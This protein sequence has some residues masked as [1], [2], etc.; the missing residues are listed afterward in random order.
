MV[1]TTFPPAFPEPLRPPSLD[2]LPGL[3][4]STAPR[5]GPPAGA[6]L[7]AGAD[8]PAGCRSFF[9]AAGRAEGC[10][11]DRL[12][13]AGRTERSRRGTA[14][15]EQG[16]TAG[17]AAGRAEREGRTA[18]AAAGQAEET[19]L[20]RNDGAQAQPVRRRFSE[21]A[22]RDSRSRS[23]AAVRTAPAC[24]RFD[25]PAQKT[26]LASY[27]IHSKIVQRLQKLS[28]TQFCA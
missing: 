17:R 21:S 9:D 11:P 13:R 22:A 26:A 27:S 14:G 10:P 1:V 23:A 15:P 7:S 12:S 5:S 6:G 2:R 24:R 25:Q 20:S 28:N 8:P 16:R 4:C 3:V 18:G 19:A